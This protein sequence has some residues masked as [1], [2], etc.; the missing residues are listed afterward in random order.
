MKIGPSARAIVC[1]AIVLLLVT[2]LAAIWELFALQAPGSPFSIGMLPG[3]IAS[4]RNT[5][6][7]FALALLSVAWLI[8]WA[9]QN[10]E[11]RLIVALTYIGVIM[12]LG[13]GFY[14]ALSGMSGVQIIDPRP[15]A[16]MVLSVKLVG[17]LLLVI[18]LVDFARRMVFRFPRSEQ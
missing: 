15:D 12:A 6:L 9:Y 17:Q 2:A 7:T 18:G 16:W 11:P 3:P 13:S 5:A 8:P 14:G 10:K 4:F 1:L